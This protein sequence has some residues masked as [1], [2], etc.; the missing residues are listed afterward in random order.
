MSVGLNFPCVFTSYTFAVDFDCK[1]V[2]SLFEKYKDFLKD[3]DKKLNKKSN[4][5]FVYFRMDNVR[6]GDYYII[7]ENNTGQV[8]C[9]KNQYK[10]N[11]FF[12]VIYNGF[13]LLDGLK[14]VKANIRF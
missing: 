13:S 5:G 1:E 7:R 11:E 10:D 12:E 14:S 9:T 8:V 6:T 4:Q 3:L 2:K